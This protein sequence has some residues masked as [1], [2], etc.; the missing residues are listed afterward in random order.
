MESILSLQGDEGI[1]NVLGLAYLWGVDIE[2]L[3]ECSLN[4][5]EV[6]KIT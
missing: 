2:T 6:G 5:Q 1:R 3:A 4:Q